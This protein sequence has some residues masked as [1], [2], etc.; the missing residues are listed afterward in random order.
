MLIN[1]QSETWL[2]MYLFAVTTGNVVFSIFCA[3]FFH[4]H[5]SLFFFFFIVELF[6]VLYGLWR[7]KFEHVASLP[8][9]FF[10]S[11]VLDG[12]LKICRFDASV[13]ISYL[14]TF[15]KARGR[16]ALANARF[17]ARSSF[18]NSTRIPAEILRQI[19]TFRPLA[20]RHRRGQY[21]LHG[22]TRKAL[23]YV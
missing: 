5:I 16:N 6:R 12:S 3:K 15:K 18:L 19:P 17:C 23:D 20:L 11:L 7:V 21:M 22:A 1:L 2:N 10:R 14:T 9:V 4:T 8:F 13:A